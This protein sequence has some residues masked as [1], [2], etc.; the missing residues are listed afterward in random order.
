[1]AT[2]FASAS[3]YIGDLA[4]DVTEANLF[5]VFNQIGAVASI[6]VCRDAITRRSLGY[7]YVNFH[8]A[9]DAERALDT[10]NNA[11]IKGR[12][13][14]IMWSQ[15]DPSLRKSG[16]GNI[17]IKNLDK[18]ID[19]KA[20]YDTFSQFG[21]ILSCKVELDRNNESKG[22]GYIQ[23]A[24]QESADKASVK[25]NNM[26]LNNKK[27]YVGPFVAKKERIQQEAK[28]DFTNIF[29][30]NLSENVSDEEIV[31][32]FS[33]FGP[34]KNAL[35]VR[36]EEGKS[37]GFAFVNYE[38]PDDAS[39]AVDE[40][41]NKEID[42][43]PVFVGRAQKKAER[44]MELK[45][46]FEQIKQ[47]QMAKYQGVNLYIKNL[48]DDIDDDKMRGIFTPFGNITSCR[49]MKDSK[50]NSKGFGFVCFTTP[51][52]ATKC[53]TEMNG[54]IVGTKPLYV[55]LAQRKDIR[56]AQ[57]EQQFNQ[58][59]KIPVPGARIPAPGAAMYGANGAPMFY[60][61]P[62]GQPGFVYGGMVPRGP[63][64][65]GRFPYQVPTNYVMVG[66]RG[67][68]KNGRGMGG[69]VPQ[70]RGMK[71]QGGHPSM[72]HPIPMGNIPPMPAV[73]PG[74][75]NII[76]QKLTSQIL[77]TFPAEEQKSILGERLYPLVM[78]NQPALAGKITGMILES[79]TS[80]E[81]LGMLD[82][83][84]SLVE[85]VDEALIVLKKH[86]EPEDK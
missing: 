57:L 51:E 83:Q 9:P 42:G 15:R 72:M 22:Y 4:P 17:F 64:G 55:G 45:Q 10:L 73:A 79:C 59:T 24:T 1:M 2:P 19:H 34:V 37:K 50:G 71:P 75:P 65:S 36:D 35:V 78:K 33:Q 69:V 56:R 12:P 86:T 3:L 47:E 31:K 8:S 82:S 18:S 32:I 48:D 84:E 16:K 28:K 63:G 7:A 43:K 67:Q 39:N 20:L 41:N 80:D 76:P 6:R 29:I 49:V 58:R 14:R 85:K 23:F 44:E 46:K 53:V 30:K 38:M 81:I 68:V 66:G 62:P 40:M 61:G 25:V 11:P 21:A 27:V 5:D 26:M 77:S 70:R 13:C 74:E 52:E 60:A 54:K